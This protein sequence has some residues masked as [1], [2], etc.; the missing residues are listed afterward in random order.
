MRRM[1]VGLLK[2]RADEIIEC[3]NGIDAVEAFLRRAPDWVL[4]DVDMPGMDGISALGRIK[5]ADAN[6]KV[7]IVTGHPDP[8]TRQAA[9]DAGANAFVSKEDLTALLDV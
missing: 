5:A 8:V 4:L 9:A 1:I 3:A 7:A 6:A 2:H